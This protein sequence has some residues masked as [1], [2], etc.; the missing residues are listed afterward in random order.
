MDVS[1][2]PFCISLAIPVVILAALQFSLGTELYV[3]GDTG[4]F[5]STVKPT[6]LS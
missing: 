5:R 3:G 6:P 1:F 4:T 2:R